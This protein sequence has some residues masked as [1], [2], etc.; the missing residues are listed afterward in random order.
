MKTQK[1]KKMKTTLLLMGHMVLFLVVEILLLQG[2]FGHWPSID[3][4]TMTGVGHL[5]YYAS[6]LLAT[7]ISMRHIGRI[8]HLWYIMP[9]MIHFLVHLLPVW[10]YGHRHHHHH[11]HIHSWILV[12]IGV[13]IL[14]LGEYFLHRKRPAL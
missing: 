4:V 9:I 14:I 13:V 6:I 7:A 10:I 8:R 2:I 3:L 5:V 1:N 12:I 11:F